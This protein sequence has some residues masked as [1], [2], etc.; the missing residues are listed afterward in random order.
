MRIFPW[1]KS[2]EF[3]S[4]DQQARLVAAI[5]AAEQRTSGEVRVYVES[6]CKF[7]DAIDRAREL[8]FE[9]GMERTEARNATL[10]YVAVTD[11]QAAVFGDEGIH[12]KVGQQYWQETVAGMLHEFRHEHLVEG[13]CLG[14]ARLGEALHHFFPYDHETD[15]NELPDDIVFGK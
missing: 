10:L 7:V 3:F 2:K 5:R 14:I 6:H 11:H 9:L 8:F 1:Q 13:M 15:K 12:R 4:P